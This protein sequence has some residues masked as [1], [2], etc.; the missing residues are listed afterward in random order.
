MKSCKCL[1]FC[2]IVFF[3]SNLLLA[4]STFITELEN[5]NNDTI[6][7]NLLLKESKKIINSKPDSA[8]IL[9]QIALSIIENS[10]EGIPIDLK[11]ELANLFH[12]TG[13]F[14]T[15]A[16]LFSQLALH[17]SIS[18]DPEKK[19]NF[20][21]RAAYAYSQLA[22]QKNAI[23]HLINA[24]ELTHEGMPKKLLEKTYIYAA[25]IYRNSGDTAKAEAY[26]EK[27][28]K[29]S[30]PLDKEGYYPVALHEKGN[31]Y[32]IK[33]N[34]RKALQYQFE[35]LELRK[36]QELK[37][38]LIFSYHDI[39]ITYSN[40]NLE[41]STR[42]YLLK[43]ITLEKEIDPVMLS[44]SY[45][46]MANSYLRMKD[47]KK[48]FSYID[49]SFHY[50]QK[51][52]LKPQLINVYSTYNAYYESIGDYKNAYFYFKLAHSYQ[53][54]VSNE[55]I[56]K[57]IK[58]FDIKFETAKKD[59]ELIKN[60]LKIKN[61]Q[62]IIF[63]FLTGLVIIVFF[64]IYIVKLN[65]KLRSSNQILSRQKNEIQ[66][67]NEEI[68]TSSD[69]I[70]KKAEE[71]QKAYSI[72]I[73]KNRMI[74]E[75]NNN[76]TE[77]ILYAERIQSALFPTEKGFSEFFT[78]SFLLFMPRDVVSGDFIWI[79]KVNKNIVFALAD[80]TGHGV[81]G[82]FVSI[83]GMSILNEISRIAIENASE[84]LEIL[85]R[86]LKQS[87]NSNNQKAEIDDGMN[88]SLCIYDPSLNTINYS[89]AYHSIFIIRENKVI[90]LSTT[91]QPIGRYPNEKPF[92][93]DYFQLKTKDQ[94]YLF[95]DGIIDQ[96]GGNNNLKLKK[97]GF[98]NALL[99]LQSSNFAQ[100]KD[101]LVSFLEKW[102]KGIKQL[103]DIT[104]L[105]IEI[106]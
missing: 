25:F 52:K 34:Y 3:Y 62:V 50:A 57:Q 92:E 86:E 43:A 103:D 54:S 59:K 48:A 12:N 64:I 29:V 87:L 26:F 55:N 45:I 10:T 72:L 56:T 58:L 102:K 27:C 47:Y 89:G 66:Q 41:D 71:L 2:I 94:L 22:D 4:Q 23:S 79:K 17:P 24:L 39:S 6:K 83:L 98:K 78:K 85:R 63:S 93:N 21:I 14:K 9:N 16:E 76:I 90:E 60:R 95:S 70:S 30:D 53:D 40:L 37:N 69:E 75:Q 19:V 88:I 18:I 15:A 73:E 28:L 1:I 20:Y 80:C 65:N 51:Y 99:S 11:A 44:Y 101:M 32:L 61:Q 100:K 49:S 35:A 31:L 46:G 33:G 104:I 96:F 105:G 5:T 13:D 82:A 68:K 38:S 91:K 67:K 42:Y 77:S 97:N 7:L 81:P 8:Q 106:E 84:W 74:E 36:R